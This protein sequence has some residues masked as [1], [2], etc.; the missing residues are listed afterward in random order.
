[1]WLVTMSASV[2]KRVLEYSVIQNYLNYLN[3]NFC[4]SNKIEELIVL[5]KSNFQSALTNLTSWDPIEVQSLA[6]LYE[7][8]CLRNVHALDYTIGWSKFLYLASNIWSN[9]CANFHVLFC[10]TEHI[11][12][13][14]IEIFR[15]EFSCI[16]T[17]LC[18]PTQSISAPKV[19]YK[20]QILHGASNHY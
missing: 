19:F 12:L 2:Y 18:H 11:I 16:A 8:Y 5:W 7:D 14:H 10:L 1:M 9:Y 20:N 6:L 13:Y 17:V 15:S 3:S 4:W